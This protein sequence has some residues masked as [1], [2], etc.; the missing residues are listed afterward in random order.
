MYKKERWDYIVLYNNRISNKK[1]KKE[2]G[3]PENRQENTKKNRARRDRNGNEI[4]RNRTTMIVKQGKENESCG[5][6]KRQRE[7]KREISQMFF[8]EN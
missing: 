4:D 2:G 7:R 1:M 5:L 3:G 6:K 8:F